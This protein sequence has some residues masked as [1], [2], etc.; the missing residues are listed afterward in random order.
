MYIAVPLIIERNVVKPV[1]SR[2]CHSLIARTQS[3]KC[4]SANCLWGPWCVWIWCFKMDFC[5]NPLR[6]QFVLTT[7]IWPGLLV[8][9]QARQP[10]YDIPF[11]KGSDINSTNDFLSQHLA[12]QKDSRKDSYGLIT[13]VVVLNHLFKTF[14]LP[15][16]L[17]MHILANIWHRL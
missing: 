7:G 6:H 8:S 9:W 3:L 12:L 14:Q 13:E 4:P 1:H 17:E 11:R 10:S 2:V 15:C 16:L 5:V